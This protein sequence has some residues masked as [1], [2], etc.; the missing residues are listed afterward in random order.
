MGLQGLAGGTNHRKETQRVVNYEGSFHLSGEVFEQRA[1]EKS[2]NPGQLRLL[3]M[4]SGGRLTT[5]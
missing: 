4:Q 3:L 1:E 2:S 5:E